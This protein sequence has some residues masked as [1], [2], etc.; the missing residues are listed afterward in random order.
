MTSRARRGREVRVAR[1]IREPID[2]VLIV[3]EGA[4][5]EP[6]YFASLR[7]ELRLG[8][9]NILVL[10]EQCGSSPM[11]VVEFAIEKFRSS[12][13]YDRIFCVFDRDGHPDYQAAIAKCDHEPVL[14]FV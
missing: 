9:A 12:R 5:T 4:K 11:T 10:G 14:N 1:E 8:T 7:N 13:D 6:H 3:C 2:V